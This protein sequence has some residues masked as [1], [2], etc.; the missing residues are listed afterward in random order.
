MKA[1]IMSLDE[2]AWEAV[3]DG[4]TWPIVIDTNVNTRFK[5]KIKYTRV[6]KGVAHGNSKALN[7]IFNGVDME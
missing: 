2:A 7:A 3:E 6:E 4:W 5:E 1:F